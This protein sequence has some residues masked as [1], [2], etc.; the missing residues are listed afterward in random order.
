MK[1]KSK[2]LQKVYGSCCNS[3]TEFAI[4]QEIAETTQAEMK[5][6]EDED[7]MIFAG[8]LQVLSLHIYVNMTYNQTNQQYDR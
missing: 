5:G 4:K 1:G 8:K 7:E 6:Y 3:I 2:T